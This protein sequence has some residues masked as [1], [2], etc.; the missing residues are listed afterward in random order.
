MYGAISSIA[1]LAAFIIAVATPQYVPDN[2]NDPKQ[3]VGKMSHQLHEELEE[4]IN[5][6]V[7]TELAASLQYMAMSSFFA[8]EVRNRPGFAKYFRKASQE[9]WEH[10]QKFVEYLGKRGTQL[11]SLSVKMPNTFSWQSGMFA[12]RDALKLE[13]TVTD[14]LSNLHFVAT[15]KK[16]AHLTDF[17]ESEF[18]PEQIES[19]RELSGY[20]NNLKA[21]THEGGEDKHKKHDALAE[22]LFDVQLQKKE[23]D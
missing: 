3:L 14:I 2:P 12:L 23:D 16:D 11:K 19:M 4:K 8:D 6:Q 20:M 21:M 18:L 13:R 7:S 22:Y 5:S 17:L 1:W 15:E 10:A 9:E